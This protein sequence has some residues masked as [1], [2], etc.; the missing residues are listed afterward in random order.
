MEVMNRLSLDRRAQVINCLTEGMSIRS[1]VR[2]TGAAKDTVIKLL[3]D[4]G[5]AAAVF[6]HI[7]FQNLACDVIEADEIWSYVYAKRDKLVNRTHSGDV[8]VWVALCADTRLVPSWWIGDRTADTCVRFLTDLRRRLAT[9]PTLQTDQWEAYRIAQE[10]V[11]DGGV[12]HSAGKTG[13]SHVERQNL[14]MR[15]NMKRFTR[16][17][18]AFSKKL[19]NHAAA[20]ALHF[21]A[22]NYGRVHQTLKKTPAMAEGLATRPWDALDIAALLE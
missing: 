5:R 13:T 21:L 2:I 12:N 8:W 3:V 9:T 18:N 15:M 4:A 7:Q 17:T 14:T 6:Q 19:E 11:F 16:R 10:E 20:V 22:Y 1:T